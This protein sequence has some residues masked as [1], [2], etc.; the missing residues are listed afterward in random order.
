MT[1]VL[2]PDTNHRLATSTVEVA[3]QMSEVL[4]TYWDD[5]DAAERE[6]LRETIRSL[7]DIADRLDL[8]DKSLL[9]LLR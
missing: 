2:P 4:A 3:N 6:E 9:T 7:Y 1:R 8:R 5:L